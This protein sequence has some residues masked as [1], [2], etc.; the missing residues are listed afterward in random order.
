MKK[1]PFCAEDIQDAARVCKH[2]GRDLVTSAT[3]Q[4]VQ[5]VTPK[6]RFGLAS[7]LFI[8]GG[9]VVIGWIGSR[10]SPSDSTA[11]GDPAIPSSNGANPAHDKLRLLSVSPRNAVF[12][13]TNNDNCNVIDHE[14]LGIDSTIASLWRLHCSGGKKYLLRVEPDAGGSSRGLDCDVAKTLKIDCYAKVGDRK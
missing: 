12:T 5:I 1:C 8:I 2:C 11:S 9:M 6:R 13:K 4:Q 14:F 10:Q 3:A 7:W